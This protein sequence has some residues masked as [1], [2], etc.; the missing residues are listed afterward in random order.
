MRITL[1]AFLLLNIASVAH[2]Q[3][4]PE[5]YHE[6]Y[7]ADLLYEKGE[8]NN[9]L[10]KYE[11]AFT[12]VDYVHSRILDKVLKVSKVAG[13]KKRIKKYRTQI[14]SQEK[15]RPE[16]EELLTKIDSILV[17]DQSA[18]G[19]NI[20]KF[21]LYYLQNVD[22]EPVHNTSEFLKAKQIYDTSH[23]IDSMNIIATLKLIDQYGFI[24]EKMIGQ[25]N[26]VN[27]RTILLH[28]D[29]DKNNKVLKPILDEA[30]E[31]N[32]ITPFGYTHII[33]RHLE[34]NGGDQIYWTWFL[35]DEEPKFSEKE[36]MD[37]IKRRE[38]IGLYG[39][40]IQSW[41]GKDGWMLNNI[42]RTAY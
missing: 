3:S 32:Q 22:N 4:I 23:R 21:V 25:Y 2:A 29:S 34:N 12:Q 17:L 10:L 41:K 15:C 40:E 26:F 38:R 24:S 1:I 13:D 39:T 9:A 35:V 27:F 33:D 42:S 8:Y 31:N 16:Y 18:R 6:I 20:D 11:E 14:K 37:I 36:K 7:K 28:F 30:L 5:F 19:G